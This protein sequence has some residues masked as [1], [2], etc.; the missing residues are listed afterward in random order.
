MMAI[1]P[2]EARDYVANRSQNGQMCNDMTMKTTWS[3]IDGIFVV[4]A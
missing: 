1:Y 3:G 4:F 2:Q